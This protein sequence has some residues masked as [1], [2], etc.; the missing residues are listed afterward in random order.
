MKINLTNKQYRLLLDLVYTGAWL[1]NAHRTDTIKT[2]YEELESYLY[3]FAKPYGLDNLVDYVHEKDKYYPSLA[4][5]ESQVREFIDEYDEENFWEELVSRLATRDIDNGGSIPAEEGRS[6]QE[7][8]AM[9]IWERED[10]YSDE[11]EEHGLDRVI[12]KLKAP[13]TKE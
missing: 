8:R 4:L 9:R 12:V 7:T 6:A 13:I 5:E 2:E 10:E 3:S 1:I 11:F